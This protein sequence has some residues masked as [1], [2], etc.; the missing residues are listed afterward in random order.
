MS[1]IDLDERSVHLLKK[2]VFIVFATTQFLEV[3]VEYGDIDVVE[4]DIFYASLFEFYVPAATYA[5]LKLTFGD[6]VLKHSK[7]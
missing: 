3:L 6:A 7:F 5:I 2:N 4:L 1:S